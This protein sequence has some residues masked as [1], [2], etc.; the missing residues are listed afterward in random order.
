[1]TRRG[2]SIPLVAA[3]AAA[4]AGCGGP[5]VARQSEV[6]SGKAAA[7]IVKLIRMEKRSIERVSTQPGEIVPSESTAIRAKIAGYVSAIHVDIGD[8][9]SQG[10]ILAEISVPEMEAELRQKE[11]MIQAAE[12]QESLARA[13]VKVA[14]A[15]LASAR[16]KVLEAKA[17]V[18][19]ADAD[20]EYCRLEYDRATQLVSRQAQSQS[21]LDEARSKRRKAEAAKAEA[22]AMC[23]SS[24]AEVLEG[25]AS[26]EKSKAQVAAATSSI[27]VAQAERDRIKA[28]LGFTRIVA[29]YD[30]VITRRNVD[31][32]HLTTSGLS[33]EPMFEM[34]RVDPVTIT[35]GV[36]E[37]DAPFVTIG[38]R[39]RVRVQALA[40][41]AFEGAVTRT[42]WSLDKAT[43]TLRVEIDHPNQK[44]ELRPGLYTRVSLVVAEKPNVWTVPA[45]AVIG[46]DAGT[47]CMVVSDGV[48]R[49]REIRLGT[50]DGK[51]FEVLSGIA[52]ED[53][54][55][56]INP[57][58]VPDG[59]QVRVEGASPR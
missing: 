18:L 11:A 32:G 44:D 34:V 59:S 39:A 20:L 12:S 9:A 50:T 41:R 37:T 42:A 33:S 3:I 43:R 17:A 27:S 38:D 36:P 6:G 26:V 28:L 30:G 57:A 1:M 2:I 48:A 40:D 7:P 47:A 4:G 25:E 29:P 56:E 21:L 16:A 19:R 45:S 13:E 35:L 52:P 55:V 22:R 31:S 53:D 51:R 24:D 58:A 5:T 23:D 15:N 8:R 54:L 14:T 10:Q 49:R 46:S